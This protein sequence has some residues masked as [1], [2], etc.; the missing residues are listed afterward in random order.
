MMVATRSRV[1]KTSRVGYLSGNI[2]VNNP[3]AVHAVDASKTWFGSRWLDLDCSSGENLTLFSCDVLT[4]G[5]V[6]G[7]RISFSLT[8]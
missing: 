3:L 8:D 2:R 6:A 1:A 4:Q 7:F 5:P